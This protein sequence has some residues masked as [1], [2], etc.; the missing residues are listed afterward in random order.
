MEITKNKNIVQPIDTSTAVSLEERIFLVSGNR[1][2]PIS[3]ESTSKY[4]IS[5]RYKEGQTI[6]HPDEPVNFLLRNNG[7]SVELGP[8]RI[9]SDKHQNNHRGRIVFLNDVYDIKCLL[10]DNKIVK[11]Q[12]AGKELP[13]I[14]ARKEKIKPEF[15]YYVAD[16][17]YDLQVYK[18][19]FDDLDSQCAD[20]PEDVRR[21]IQKAVF[22][23]EAAYFNKFLDQKLDELKDTVSDFSQE[24]HHSHG[25]YFRKQLW[26]FILCCPIFARSNLKPRG[27]PGDSQM[28]RM[29]YLNDYQGDSTFAKL[30]HKHG[31]DHPA[32]QSVR[33]RIKLVGNLLKDFATDSSGTIPK[34]LRILSV[35]SGPAFELNEV[36]KSQRDCQRYHFTLL[37]QDSAAHSEAAELVFDI[38]EKCDCKV[39]VDYQKCSIR[40]MLFSKKLVQKIGQFDFIYS[41]GLFDYLAMPV[42]KALFKHLFKLLE[43][44]GEMVIGNFHV[45][46]PSKYYMEYWCDWALFH[47]TEEELMDILADCGRVEPSI[48][49]ENTRS[50]MFLDVKKPN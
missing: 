40:T 17:K 5:F 27:Y 9:L 21:L 32:S 24:E 29:L 46:N 23:G 44:G 31:V 39:D 4:S 50:Q 22:K 18:N 7:Q 42:A 19:F 36:L 47:R 6:T 41:M 11:L 34:K 45:S 28:M 49:Y 3:V 15:K 48:L 35:G 12:S 10:E 14:F 8:C 37:D 1:R 33:N 20:E 2:I 26:N 25:F 38:E 16:L 13:F 43:P 30:F